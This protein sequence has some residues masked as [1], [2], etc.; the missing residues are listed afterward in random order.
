MPLAYLNLSDSAITST[1]LIEAKKTLTKGVI[2][3]ATEQA[4][5]LLARMTGQIAEYGIVPM[6]PIPLDSAVTLDD[7][8]IFSIEETEPI[9]MNSLTTCKFASVAF[10][11]NLIL[12]VQ[13]PSLQKNKPRTLT[14]QNVR[15]DSIGFDSDGRRE[16]SCINKLP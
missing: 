13:H 4:G 10:L 2:N 15:R 11:S 5:K 8:M 1:V 9:I 14:K 16:S 7:S 12:D 3:Q 6:A